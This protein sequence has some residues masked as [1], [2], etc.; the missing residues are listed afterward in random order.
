MNL[1]YNLRHARVGHRLCH[2]LKMVS[3]ITR[4]Q[5]NACF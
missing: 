2:N 5:D 4:I 3:F 1:S